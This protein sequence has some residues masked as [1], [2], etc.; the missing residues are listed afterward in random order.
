MF[1]SN[2]LLPSAKNTWIFFKKPDLTLVVILSLSVFFNIMLIFYFD[3][4][5]HILDFLLYL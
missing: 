3:S 4:F 5:M 2:N 1:F